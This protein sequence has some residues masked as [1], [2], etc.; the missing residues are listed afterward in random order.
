MN[1]PSLRERATVGIN[2]ADLLFLPGLDGCIPKPSLKMDTP[3][4]PR[5]RLLQLG[6]PVSTVCCSRGVTVTDDESSTVFI[7]VGG[8]RGGVAIGSVA[9]RP[10]P[11][12]VDEDD[13][14]EV[15]ACLKD[16]IYPTTNSQVVALCIG[17]RR[18]RLCA[19]DASGLIRVWRFDLSP[20]LQ[21]KQLQRET[22]FDVHACNAMSHD[23]VTSFRAC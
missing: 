20:T 19:V 16:T 9:H 11:R 4:P 13:D 15:I 10:N 14:D 6:E 17:R 12:Y 22:R 18:R 5:P 3:L 21:I 7:A 8:R 1:G 2:R 23:A